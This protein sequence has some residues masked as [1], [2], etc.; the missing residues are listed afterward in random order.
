MGFGSVTVEVWVLS[1]DRAFQLSQR[2]A[3]LDAEF[4]GE[5]APHSLVTLQC[6]GLPPASVEA[7]DQLP[8]QTF[9][10]RV[11][12]DQPFE[13]ADQLCM[14]ALSEFGLYA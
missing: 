7:Q 4:V 9:V 11:L 10:K 14:P 2:S 8:M 3:R 12:G 13:C 5:D 1:E 6:L